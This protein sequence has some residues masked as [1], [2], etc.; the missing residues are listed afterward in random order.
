MPDR[1]TLP[2]LWSGTV[3]AFDTR[4]GLSS[5]V[6]NDLAESRNSELPL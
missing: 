4:I 2:Y 3:T 6:S 5:S 1:E